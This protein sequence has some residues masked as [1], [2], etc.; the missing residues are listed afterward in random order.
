M[1]RPSITFLHP[2]CMLAGGATT[3]LL[4]VSKR[5]VLAGWPVHVVSVQSDLAI[6]RE[7]RAAGV[8]F[9]RCGRAA[10]FVNLVLGAVSAHVLAGTPGSAEN[11][12][13]DGGVR[14]VSSQLVGVVL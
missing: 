9:C 2:H 7:A 12:V 14:A 11:W 10:V 13:A 4:E 3:V 5:L 6:V 8:R 1:Q